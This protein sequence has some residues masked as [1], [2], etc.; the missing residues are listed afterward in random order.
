[1]EWLVTVKLP[2]PRGLRPKES[3]PCPVA[4]SKR[5]T[6]IHGAHHTVKAFG[7]LQA[8]QQEFAGVHVTRMEEV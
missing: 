6:D 1:M 5:C 4:P 3:G 7:S 2:V 8:V